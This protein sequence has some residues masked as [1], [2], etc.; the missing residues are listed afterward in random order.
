MSANPCGVIDVLSVELSSGP[1]A[2]D[3]AATVATTAVNVAQGLEP[4][5]SSFADRSRLGDFR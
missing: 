2:P 1:S 5:T 4:F 3:A